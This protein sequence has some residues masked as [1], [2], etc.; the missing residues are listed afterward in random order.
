[1]SEY[2]KIILNLRYKLDNK[3]ESEELDKMLV[4]YTD[5]IFYKNGIYD[6]VYYDS[7]LTQAETLFVCKFDKFIFRYKDMVFTDINSIFYFK[8]NIKFVGSMWDNLY[9]L[10]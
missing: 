3:Y 9:S 7:S 10:K 2:D 5:K 8:K 4:E 6:K 1:M